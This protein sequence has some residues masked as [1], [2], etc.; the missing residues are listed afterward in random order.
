M[1][2]KLV[3]DLESGLPCT[4][5]PP[6]GGGEGVTKGPLWVLL[7]SWG[8]LPGSPSLEV[9]ENALPTAR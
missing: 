5:G 2:L 9:S 4:C 1:I 6:S 8:G 3:H 7:L